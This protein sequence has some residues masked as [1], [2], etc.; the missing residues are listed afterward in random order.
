M[1]HL[2]RIGIGPSSSHTM[3]P[4]S[5]AKIY[6]QRHPELEARCSQNATCRYLTTEN[7]DAFRKHAQLF[8]HEDVEEV[9]NITLE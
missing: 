6:L 2:Y 5:A 8:L 1:R 9:E 4:Q 7:P 3:G